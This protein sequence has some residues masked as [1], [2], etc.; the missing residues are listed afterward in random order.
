MLIRKFKKTAK[1][2]FGFL[3]EYGFKERQVG[4]GALEQ[5]LIFEKERW[6]ISICYYECLDQNFKKGE[7]VDIVLEYKLNNEMSTIPMFGI[8]EFGKIGANLRACEKLFGREKINQLNS[9][10]VNL[11]LE[12]QMSIQANFLKKNLIDLGLHV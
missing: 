9:S 8:V 4:Y 3:L 1:K 5:N 12:E 7:A 11:D 10:L 6:T 2:N